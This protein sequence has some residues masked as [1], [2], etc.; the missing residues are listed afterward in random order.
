[1][2]WVRS[3]DQR[4]QEKISGATVA[5]VICKRIKEGNCTDIYWEQW[6]KGTALILIIIKK[7]NNKRRK[8][9]TPLSRNPTPDPWT[10]AEDELFQRTKLLRGGALPNL[11][12]K[13][14]NFLLKQGNAFVTFLHRDERFLPTALESGNLARA[15]LQLVHPSRHASWHGLLFLGT[16]L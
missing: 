5:I 10:A 11:D 9:K 2:L 8:K 13:C 16:G 15:L 3:H 4:L 6:K 12:S 7:N 14:P 1:M